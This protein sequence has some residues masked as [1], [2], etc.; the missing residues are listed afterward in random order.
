MDKLDEVFAILDHEGVKI[1][2]KITQ[3]NDLGMR[4]FGVRDLDGNLIQIFGR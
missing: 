2:F 4:A 3:L 1:D